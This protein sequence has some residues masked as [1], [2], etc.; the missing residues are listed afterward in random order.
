MRTS[1]GAQGFWGER[2]LRI[3]HA[4]AA[5]HAPP[6]TLESL[7]LA[8]DLGVDMV[9]FDVLAC[10]DALV[11]LHDDDLSHFPGGQGLASEHS[12][13]ELG[14]LDLG[15]GQRIPS[16]AE[17]LDLIGGRAL[18]NVDLK[19][20]GYEAEVLGHLGEAGVMADVLISSLLPDSL[21]LLRQLAPAVQTG[22]SYPEDRGNASARPH[23]QPAV[24][25]AVKLIRYVLPYRLLGMMAHAQANAAMLYH[26]VVSPATVDRVHQAGG[27]V[28]VW[29]VDDLPTIC[30]VQAMGV[31]GIASNR[32]NLFAELE[33]KRVG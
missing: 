21:R 4:G 11:L 9:E 6:N 33:Q 25:L 26:R 16:L 31:D 18:M 12:L 2:F 17:A 5:A 28:S 30:R 8:L 3:G 7:A 14:T 1:S 22:F 29:T 27:R 24:T 15:G 10:T 32:P 13:E 23:L 19:A 20:A